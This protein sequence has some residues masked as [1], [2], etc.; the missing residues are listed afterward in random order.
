MATWQDRQLKRHAKDVLAAVPATFSVMYAKEPAGSR[1]GTRRKSDMHNY[2]R[3]EIEKLTDEWIVGRNAERDRKI[4]KRRLLD[5]ITFDRLAEEFD[6][7][8]MQV[9][10][11][12]Y[13]REDELF[14]HK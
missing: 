12:V 10:N 7:S 2:S 6:L 11:I 3:S 1:T 8:V 9:K 5:G 14:C 4:L 13:R